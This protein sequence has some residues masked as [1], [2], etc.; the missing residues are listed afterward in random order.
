MLIDGLTD[1]VTRRFDQTVT[2]E[3][4]LGSGIA[5]AGA[6]A[7]GPIVGAAVYLVDRLPEIRWIG[8]VVIVIA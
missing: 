1:L 7:G 5:L 3:P 6:V 2:V 4:K 8:W